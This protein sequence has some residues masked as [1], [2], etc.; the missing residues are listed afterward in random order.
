MNITPDKEKQLKK[1]KKKVDILKSAIEN[2]FVWYSDG[3]LVFGR[4]NNL[5]NFNCVVD[6]FYGGR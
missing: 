3:R 4:N 6:F 1:E 5:M 2:S